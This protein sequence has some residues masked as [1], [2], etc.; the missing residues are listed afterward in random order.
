M[1]FFPLAIPIKFIWL[2]TETVWGWLKFDA[3]AKGANTNVTVSGAYSMSGNASNSS[4]IGACDYRGSCDTFKGLT[5]KSVSIINDWHNK[6]M[7]YNIF[8]N[9]WTWGVI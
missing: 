8:I 2:V 4:R 7:C 9:R 6:I 5:L 3:T 1:S